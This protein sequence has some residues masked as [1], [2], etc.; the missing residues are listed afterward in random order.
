[1]SGWSPPLPCAPMHHAGAGF[2]EWRWPNI[3]AHCCMPRT[4]MRRDPV[5]TT[6]VSWSTCLKKRVQK[7]M[8]W[9]QHPTHASLHKSTQMICPAAQQQR[10]TALLVQPPCCLAASSHYRPNTPPLAGRD[11]AGRCAWA[12]QIRCEATSYI[13]LPTS[14]HRHRPEPPTPFF[15][16]SFESTQL[17]RRVQPKRKQIEV[18]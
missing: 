15:F 2:P 11:A 4:I 18:Q 9:S 3:P 7:T 6:M 17:A 16:F 13:L 5:P 14:H 12:F 10:P 8:L 1:M